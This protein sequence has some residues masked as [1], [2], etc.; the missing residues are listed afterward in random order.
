MDFALEHF[1]AFGYEKASTNQIIRQAGISKGI[2]FH[3]FTSKRQLYLTVLDRGLSRIGEFMSRETAAAPADLFDRI[4]AVACAKL[5][6]YMK[7]PATYKLL[8]DAFSFPPLDEV[9]DELAERRRR[10]AEHASVRL[11]DIDCSKLRQ[12][13]DPA[14][15]FD[16]VAGVANWLST[17][18]IERHREQPDGGLSR[19][20]AFVD[21]LNAHLRMLKTGIY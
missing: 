10:M 11:E 9:K 16:L 17:R 13:V 3:Y 12:D 14:M 19:M 1:A 21:E 20:E 8:V 7:E 5:R 6:F 15:A 4:A 18:F 2:L